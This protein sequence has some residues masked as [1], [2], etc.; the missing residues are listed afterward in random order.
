M[1]ISAGKKVVP[2]RVVIYGPEGIGKST[3]ASKFP[4]PL[5]IDTEGSTYHIDVDRFEEKPDTWPMLLAQ[6]E[7][8]KKNSDICKTL[9]ID[10]ADW[11]EALAKSHISAKKGW[12]SIG[13]PDYGKGYLELE[14]VF[15]DMLNALTDII[16]KDINVVLV[17]HSQIKTFTKPDEQG[18]YDRYELK[19][20]K[21]TSALLKEWA[22]AVIF[23]NYESFIA[24]KNRSGKGTAT[25]GRRAMYLEHKPAWDAK[26]RWGLSEDSYPL[27]Y[28]VIKPFIYE[29]SGENSH[30]KEQEVAKSSV[31]EEK[32]DDF[33]ETKAEVPFKEEEEVDPALQQLMD[34]EGFT[35]EDVLEVIYAKGIYP[36]D[37]PY[38]AMD[39][40]FIQ[41]AVIGRWDG[42]KNVIKELKENNRIEF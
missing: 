27:E 12:S 34:A 28:S 26:N 14:K 11:A 24:G 41:G 31:L 18:S 7:H 30:T 9:V 29:S 17:A 36:R 25:G 32:K 2:Q 40:S 33:I 10:T 8:V 35:I 5:V 15:G 37:T 19:L 42:L 20:E 6:I 3:L 38:S 4:K 16:K 21:K 23:I 39:E 13:D 22:D 1:R